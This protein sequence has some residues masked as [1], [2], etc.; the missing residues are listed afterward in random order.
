MGHEIRLLVGTS[1][2]M[3]LKSLKQNTG[4][5]TK[6]SKCLKQLRVLL[7]CLLPTSEHAAGGGTGHGQIHWMSPSLQGTQLTSA[8]APQ[9]QCLVPKH[10][11]ALVGIS[12]TFPAGQQLND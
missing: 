11:G 5:H 1:C 8:K 3:L 6:T 9:K 7:R 10:L 4:N 12:I 2:G